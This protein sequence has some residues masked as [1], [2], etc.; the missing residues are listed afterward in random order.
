M[1]YDKRVECK[2]RNPPMAESLKLLMNSCYGR[3]GM[4]A[5]ELCSYIHEL[6]L[7]GFSPDQ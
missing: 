5:Y 7:D 4:K 1:M 3:F 6:Q 2:T